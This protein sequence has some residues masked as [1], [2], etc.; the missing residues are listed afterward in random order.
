MSPTPLWLVSRGEGQGQLARS[1]GR[2]R[3]LGLQGLCALACPAG[4]LCVK[5]ISLLASPFACSAS[6]AGSAEG[7]VFLPGRRGPAGARSRLR[8]PRESRVPLPRVACVPHCRCRNAAGG[9]TGGPAVPV[10]G[11][12]RKGLSCVWLWLVGQPSGSLG[13]APVASLQPP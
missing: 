6:C 9:M 5:A 4:Q 12:R 11:C 2:K 10:G 8:S 1:Q 7:V 13:R 3:G